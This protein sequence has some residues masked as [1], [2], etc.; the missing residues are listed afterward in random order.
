LPSSAAIDESKVVLICPDTRSSN[1]QL[2]IINTS[3]GQLDQLPMDFNNESLGGPAWTGDGQQIYF[4]AKPSSN[5][6]VSFFIVNTDGNV[7]RK[8]IDGNELTISPDGQTLTYAEDC[9]VLWLMNL[10]GS[11]RY[12]LDTPGV[13][14]M[15]W[16]RWSPDNSRLAFADLFD[17]QNRTPSVWVINQDGSGLKNI[18]Q[19]DRPI[20]WM[21]GLVW[22]PDG[23]SIGIWY[24]EEEGDELIGLLLDPDGNADS[25]SIDW[26]MPVWWTPA[27]WPQWGIK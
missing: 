22:S 13:R 3:S 4:M 26:A 16:L 6:P 18:Y 11:G 1:Q 7:V 21:G 24:A 10:D 25:Q 9:Q 2:C 20:W 14:C 23:K 19:L 27:F 12:Y 8:L 17:H 5:S 15:A